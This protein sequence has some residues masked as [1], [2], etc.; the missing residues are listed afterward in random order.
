VP[1]EENS[2]PWLASPVEDMNP[3]KIRDHTR[4]G[5]TINR[6]SMAKPDMS[7]LKA[8]PGGQLILNGGNH[9]V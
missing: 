7:N 5:I 3:E 1:D 2:R 6:T 9:Y 4:N 8:K